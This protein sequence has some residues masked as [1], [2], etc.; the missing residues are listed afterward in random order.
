M[1]LPRKQIRVSLRFSSIP[2]PTHPRPPTK[3]PTC[4]NH[5]HF[6]VTCGRNRFTRSSRR[7]RH[8][9]SSSPNA[10]PASIGDSNARPVLMTGCRRGCWNAITSTT[11]RPLKRCT[12]PLMRSSGTSTLW[13]LMLWCKCRS[14]NLAVSS[15]EGVARLVVVMLCRSNRMLTVIYSASGSLSIEGSQTSP[16]PT[17]SNF[18]TNYFCMPGTKCLKT[19]EVLLDP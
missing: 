5:Q 11:T 2:C 10:M 17:A 8:R 9:P 14:S 19:L 18:A 7:S 15:W 13:S 16:M 3:L 12:Y 1:Q 4:G 6:P